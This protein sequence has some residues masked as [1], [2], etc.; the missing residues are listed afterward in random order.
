MKSI[1]NEK[2][3]LLEELSDQGQQILAMNGKLD[4]NISQAFIVHVLQAFSVDAM[5]FECTAQNVHFY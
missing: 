4:T 5:L 1:K 2:K 3:T